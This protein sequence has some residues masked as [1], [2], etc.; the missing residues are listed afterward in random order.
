MKCKS[1]LALLL[2]LVLC[3]GLAA[4]GNQGE[5]QQPDTPDATDTAEPD[6]PETPAFPAAEIGTDLGQGIEN[7]SFTT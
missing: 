6:E 3:L 7:F 1:L 2:A 5:T 4:C